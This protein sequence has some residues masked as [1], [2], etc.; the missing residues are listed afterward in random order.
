ME[1]YSPGG[2]VK[3]EMRYRRDGYLHQIPADNNKR[4]DNLLLNQ[5]I[6]ALAA[7]QDEEWCDPRFHAR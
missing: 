6:T 7:G 5:S 4:R 2:E 3:D 1:K